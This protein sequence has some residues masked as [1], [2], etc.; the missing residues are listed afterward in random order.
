MCKTKSN[1]T[2]CTLRILIL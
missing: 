2:S 1:I